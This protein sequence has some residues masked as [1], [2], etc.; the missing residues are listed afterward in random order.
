MNP[1]DIKE[2][3]DGLPFKKNASPAQMLL[4]IFCIVCILGTGVGAGIFAWDTRNTVMQGIANVDSKVGSVKQS[5]DWMRR[6]TV[7][8][9]EWIQWNLDFDR[10]NRG[11]VPG[12]KVIIPPLQLPSGPSTG[13]SDP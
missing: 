13:S 1:G 11:T 6:S 4:L 9:A 12:L 3:L 10:V 5:Q 8:R 7:T 2:A